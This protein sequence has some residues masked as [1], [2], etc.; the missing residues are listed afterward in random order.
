MENIK[1]IPEFEGIKLGLSLEETENNLLK[2]GYEMLDNLDND[3]SFEVPTC[4]YKNDKFII[5]VYVDNYPEKVYSFNIKVLNNRE[6]LLKLLKYKKYYTELY[7]ES[8][9]HS[10][11]SYYWN[12]DRTHLEIEIKE[13]IFYITINYF[14]SEKVEEETL[15]AQLRNKLGPIWNLIPFIENYLQDEIP[16]PEKKKLLE[17]LI[18]DC[19]NSQPVI[20]ELVDKIYEP[21]TA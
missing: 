11:H 9:R 21:P 20:L 16:D 2:A 14:G 6:N 10:F 1:I 19:K 15:S 5:Y 7:G 4:A 8:K 3:Y 17:K 13:N 18:V 12:I